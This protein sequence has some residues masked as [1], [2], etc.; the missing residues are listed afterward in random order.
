MLDRVGDVFVSVVAEEKKEDLKAKKQNRLT[1]RRVREIQ[2]DMTRKVYW[3]TVFLT[4]FAAFCVLCSGFGFMILSDTVLISLIGLT[5][6]SPVVTAI[7]RLLN[8]GHDNTN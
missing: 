3:Y 8:K 5:A 2:A 7:D 1:T 4:S 6:I